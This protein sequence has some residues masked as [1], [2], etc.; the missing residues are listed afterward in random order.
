L[1]WSRTSPREEQVRFIERWQAGEVSFVRLCQQFGISTKTGYKRIHRFREHDWAGLA[2]RSRA[3]GSHPRQISRGVAER[4]VAAKR[5]HLTW[6]PR[7]LIP[8]L[9]A[10]HPEITWPAPSTAGTILERAGLV[11]RKRR[12]R[13]VAPWT[14]PFAEATLP[15]DVWCMDFKGWFRTTDG[16]RCDPLTVADAASRYLLVCQGLAHPRG[17]EVRPVLERAFREYG[18]PQVIRTDNGPPFASTGLGGLSQLSVWWV[19]LGI[20]PERIVPGHPEQNGRL[21]RFHR[22]LKAETAN[23]PRPSL[24]A[25][26]RSFTAFRHQYNIDRPHEALGYRTP[27]SSYRPSLRSYPSRVPEPDYGSGITVRRVRTNGTIKWQGGLLYLSESLC[28]EPVGLQPQ[29]DRYWSIQF[30]PLQIGLL[31]TRGQQVLHI[32]VEVLPMFPV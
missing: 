19:K 24:R 4:L 31:D 22:T 28:G 18:L 6:G 9:H 8:W 7:K 29:D 5:A 1:P 10:R 13:R 32:P 23:P 11:R 15:N 14:E 25:Q 17:H 27:A 20:I 12:S 2:D 30:G 26:Q 3:P 21:E 16:Q